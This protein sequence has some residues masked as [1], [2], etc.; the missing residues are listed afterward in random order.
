MS[1]FGDAEPRGQLPPRVQALL[2]A[3]PQDDHPYRWFGITHENVWEGTGEDRR[4]YLLLDTVSGIHL[5]LGAEEWMA[6]GM[7]EGDEYIGGCCGNLSASQDIMTGV[8]RDGGWIEGADLLTIGDWVGGHDGFEWDFED[9][10]DEEFHTRIQRLQ[11]VIAKGQQPRPWPVIGLVYRAVEPML[12]L[13]QSHEPIDRNGPSEERPHTTEE[14][15]LVTVLERELSYMTW[16]DLLRRSDD[17]I[18]HER[19]M[20]LKRAKVLPLAQRLA[21]KLQEHAEEEYDG[22]ALVAP[23]TDRV[24][25][26]YRGLCVYGSEEEAQ[27]VLDVW[28]RMDD[29]PEGEIVPCKTTLQQGLVIGR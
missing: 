28:A 26:N 8:F 25:S 23:G 19:Q 18:S 24:L 4:N 16:A 13:T 6:M 21:Q 11:A 5:P 15:D 22:F 17:I 7:R 12:K 20:L 3:F 14:G 27:H 9:V 10:S 1:I 2:E 29:Q